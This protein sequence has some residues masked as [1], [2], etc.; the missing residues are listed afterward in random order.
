M[1]LSLNKTAGSFL[2]IFFTFYSCAMVYSGVSVELKAISLFL[3]FVYLYFIVFTLDTMPLEKKAVKYFFIL[4]FISTIS[5]FFGDDHQFKIIRVVN[6]G[7]I[8]F[9]FLS[10]SSSVMNSF[11]DGMHLASVLLVI[12]FASINENP[13]AFGYIAVLTALF[14]GKSNWYLLSL[15]VVMFAF[16]ARGAAL[17]VVLAGAFSLLVAKELMSRKTTG[18]FL[19]AVI[20]LL[21]VVQYYI[22]WFEYDNEF[23]NDILTKRPYIW[24][25]YLNEILLDE[26]WLFGG[27][28]SI[29]IDVAEEAGQYVA[30]YSDHSRSYS[31][32]SSFIILVYEYGLITAMLMLSIFL[33]IAAENIRNDFTLLLLLFLAMGFVVPFQ[34]GGGRVYDYLFL[35]IVAMVIRPACTSKKESE[36]C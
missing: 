2:A 24:S 13:N 4:L 10:L 19:F 33:Y 25:F 8:L 21:L 31:P 17:F 3:F 11:F 30:L 28:G 36:Y 23:L 1:K 7:V 14:L 27:R 16:G 15:A 6:L 34:I 12:V 26:S 5:Y 18:Y 35:L 22:S 29:G 9:A 32:H 20:V